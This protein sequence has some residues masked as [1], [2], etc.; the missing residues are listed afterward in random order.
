MTHFDFSALNIWAI[1]VASVLNMVIGA[2]W[3]SM[4]LF[5]KPWM[6]GLGLKEEDLKPK[7]TLYIITFLLGV[8]MAILLALFLQGVDSALHGMAYAAVI[9]LGFVIPMM[10]THY[11]FEGRKSKLIFIIAGHTLVVFLIFGALLGGWQ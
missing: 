9:A 1:V 2:V 6:A 8:L 11:L 3:F 4:P 7:P 5:G 10:A